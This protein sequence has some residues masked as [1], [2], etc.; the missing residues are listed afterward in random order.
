MDIAHIMVFYEMPLSS[1]GYEQMK[2]RIARHTSTEDPVYYHI[3]ADNIT[4]QRIYD[5]VTNGV[6]V[7]TKLI[8]QW[9]EEI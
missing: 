5:S 2:G 3:L 4:E 6:N 8:E 9:M 7:S 1:I